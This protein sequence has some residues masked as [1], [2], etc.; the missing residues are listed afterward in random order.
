MSSPQMMT[1]FGFFSW[2]VA[3]VV[4]TQAAT[5]LANANKEFRIVMPPD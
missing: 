4:A 2:A 5:I 1:M 3:Q